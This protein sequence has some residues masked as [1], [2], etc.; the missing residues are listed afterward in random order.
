MALFLNLVVVALVF[1]PL[2]NHLFAALEV[3][4]QEKPADA[5]V[6][7]SSG[8]YKGHLLSLDSYNRL[9]HTF[10]LYQKG[11]AGKIFICGG[12]DEDTQVSYAGVLEAHLIKMGIPR[13][14]IFIEEVSQNTYENLKFVKP[15]LAEHAI[16]QF[17]LVTS[18]YHMFRS[19][20]ISQKLGLKAIPSPVPCYEKHLPNFY[21]RSSHLCFVL[22]EYGAITY[23]W[24]RGG[25]SECF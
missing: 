21:H 19:V 9:F 1:T 2:L 20:K 12:I 11:L 6:L 10:D 4:G 22:R 14:D 24:L 8:H 23:F 5:I 17:L 16:G 3:S 15:L 25:Y 13:E 7:L 18:S